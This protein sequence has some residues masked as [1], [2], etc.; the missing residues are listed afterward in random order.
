[1]SEKK[2]PETPVDKYNKLSRDLKHQRKA[3]EQHKEMLKRQKS[4]WL[5]SLKNCG[6][7]QT[8]INPKLFLIKK[9][10]TTKSCR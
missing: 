4:L 10:V 3:L 5:K 6:F 8:A 1:M 7:V 9:N 2:A